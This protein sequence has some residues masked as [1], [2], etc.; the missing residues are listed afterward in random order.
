M[1]AGA[2]ALSSRVNLF[3]D[4]DDP[5][6]SVLPNFNPE[7]RKKLRTLLSTREF[8]G[9]ILV[10]FVQDLLVSERTTVATLMVGLL[11]L[12]RT[13]S[14]PPISNYRVGVVARGAKRQ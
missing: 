8:S 12:A 13:F 3:A 6:A 2:T 1:S 5:L 14:H 4:A 7:S 10:G 9:Q 11:P